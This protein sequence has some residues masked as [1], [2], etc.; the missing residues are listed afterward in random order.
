MSPLILGALMEEQLRRS[1]EALLARTG[2][3]AADLSKDIG[4]D[5]G[6]LGDFLAGRKRSITASALM[7]L[8]GKLSCDPWELM[9]MTPP[10]ALRAPSLPARTAEAEKSAS[11]QTAPRP[12]TPRLSV[13]GYVEEGAFRRSGEFSGPSARMEAIAD[14]ATGRQSLLAVVGDDYASWGMPP[15]SILH[16]VSFPRYEA[17]ASQGRILVLREVGSDAMAMT[18]LRKA[19]VGGDGLAELMSPNGDKC[20]LAEI[21]EG[22]SVVGMIVRQYFAFP[23]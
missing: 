1:L 5:K 17:V 23:S 12:S 10:A 20:A 18:V 19:A 9:G 13:S 21:G 14:V 22:R 3:T 4:L 8:A 16:L 2:L 7:Q 11:P 15:G 6:Y